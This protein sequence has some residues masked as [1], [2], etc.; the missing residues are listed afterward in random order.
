MSIFNGVLAKN[1][2]SAHVIE[3]LHSCM[4]TK[5]SVT[6]PPANY[7][8]AISFETKSDSLLFMEN[9]LQDLQFL[10]SEF[11]PGTAICVGDDFLLHHLSDEKF[12]RDQQN[13]VKF[14]VSALKTAKLTNVFSTDCNYFVSLLL[15][16]VIVFILHSWYVFINLLSQTVELHTVVFEF[17]RKLVS[18]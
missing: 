5:S 15:S 11:F 12:S 3:P 8:Y 4:A 17:S 2:T 14:K 6:E 13:T 9:I 10:S 18:A 7:S 1:K 16:F